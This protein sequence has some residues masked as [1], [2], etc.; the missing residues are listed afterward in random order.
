MSVG[1]NTALLMYSVDNSTHT[2]PMETIRG[3]VETLNTE[4]TVGLRAYPSPNETK[5]SVLDRPQS[6]PPEQSFLFVQKI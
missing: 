5:E 3:G 6:P 4:T 1:V 2:S